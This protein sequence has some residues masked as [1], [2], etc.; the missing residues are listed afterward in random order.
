MQWMSKH[1]VRVCVSERV[2]WCVRVSLSWSSLLSQW[3]SS[4]PHTDCI[5]VDEAHELLTCGTGW[6]KG[7][8]FCFLFFLIYLSFLPSFFPSLLHFPWILPIWIRLLSL[9][10]N[11][12][13]FLS[14]QSLLSL[15]PNLSS[16][17][18]IPT[19]CP[20]Q[21]THTLPFPSKP[22]VTSDGGWGWVLRQRDYVLSPVK[23]ASASARLLV[24]EPWKRE[25]E[26]G[27]MEWVHHHRCSP[28]LPHPF[29]SSIASSEKGFPPGNRRGR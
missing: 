29:A 6:F 5:I 13:P 21:H 20:L 25:S 27:N 4:S 17:P 15:A 14:S 2:H 9:L 24:R 10:I 7:P 22:W 28:S 12:P 26:R 23:P 1:C 16:P 8:S 18:H 11:P 3:S 19:P